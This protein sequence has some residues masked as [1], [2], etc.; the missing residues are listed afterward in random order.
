M[1]PETPIIWQQYHALLEHLPEMH[2]QYPIINGHFRRLDSGIAGEDN[3]E[4]HL[5]QAYI[6]SFQLIKRLR[7][8]HHSSFQLDW[9]I[10]TPGFRV[11]LEVKNYTGIIYFDP[12]SN[13]LIREKDGI[14]RTFDDPLLQVDRQYANLRTYLSDHEIQQ[15][16]VYRAAVF[17]NHHAILQ[18][19]DYPEHHRILTSQAVPAFL[20]KLSAKHSPAI[21]E[22][23][24]RALVEFL[25]ENHQERSISILE[26]HHILWEDLI[27]GVPCPHCQRR[28]MLRE[29]MRWQCSYCGTRSNDAHL[30]ML[31]HL[32]L[33]TGNRLTKKLVQEFL[34]LDSP[35]ATRKLILRAGYIKFGESKQVYYSH[36]YLVQFFKSG[37]QMRKS[38]QQ[39][40]KSGQ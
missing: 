35:E 24:N 30:S 5:H 15:L 16:P 38:G 19:H 1:I 36:P 23:Q 12:K 9:I 18:L 32:A 11:I 7:L 13:Q 37:Q 4:Y 14:T 34:M 29:R 20:E 21:T 28:G 27:K 17:V 3:L 2:T 40:Q 33:L 39:I 31:Y 26:K 25:Q 22:Q 8:E 6:P 10:L